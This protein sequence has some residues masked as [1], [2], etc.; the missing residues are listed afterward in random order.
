M[1]IL[2][3]YILNGSTVDPTVSGNVFDKFLSKVTSSGESQ[4]PQM[5]LDSTAFVYIFQ[6]DMY[7]CCCLSTESFLYSCGTV[8]VIEN[9]NEFYKLSAGFIGTITQHSVKANVVLI[10]EIVMETMVVLQLLNY[11]LL[12][13]GGNFQMQSVDKIR[14]QIL[15]KVQTPKESAIQSLSPGLIFIDIVEKVWAT[16]CV[17]GTL[18]RAEVSGSV[19]LHCYLLHSPNLLLSLNTDLSTNLKEGFNPNIQF[20]EVDFSDGLDTSQLES[21]KELRLVATPGETLLFRYSLPPTLPHILPFTLEAS[22][23]QLTHR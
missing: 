7:W 2:F 10:Q 21:K 12:Q 13:I 17:G 18:L 4:P 8:C 16:V 3:I 14:P 6:D 15:S 5:I 11:C 22:H 19:V 23:K 1:I 20:S 9:L